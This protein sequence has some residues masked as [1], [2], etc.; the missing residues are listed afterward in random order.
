MFLLINIVLA[1][2]V[3]IVIGHPYSPGSYSKYDVLKHQG[4]HGPYT[5][6]I[7]H[8]IDR[9][10][11]DRCAVEHAQVVSNFLTIFSIML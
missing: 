11:P 4:G 9:R 10:L 2:V 3:P 7:G 8:G 5:P 1:L 6:D